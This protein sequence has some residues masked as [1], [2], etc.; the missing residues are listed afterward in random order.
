M[1]LGQNYTLKDQKLHILPN[2][3]LK[4]IIE[5]YPSMEKEY[6]RLELKNNKDS[7]RQKEAFASLSPILR[8]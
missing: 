6:K 1:A 3:W 7:Q 4:P 8:G 2:E 5:K